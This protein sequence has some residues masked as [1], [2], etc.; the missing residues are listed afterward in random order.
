LVL[1]ITLVGLVLILIVDVFLPA[2][3]HSLSLNSSLAERLE[4]ALTTLIILTV[5]NV[6][7]HLNSVAADHTVATVS[8]LASDLRRELTPVQDRVR[9]LDSSTFYSS[10]AGACLRATHAVDL[11]YFRPLPPHGSPT[12]AKTAAYEDI[13]KLIA[14]RADLRIRLLVNGSSD[15]RAWVAN[16]GRSASGSPNVSI[17]FLGLSVPPDTLLSAQVCDGETTYLDHVA[18]RRPGVGRDLL[19]LSSEA[20]AIFAEYYDRLWEMRERF[21]DHGATVPGDAAGV[22]GDGRSGHELP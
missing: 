20:S 1:L 2:I 8:D 16:V 7:F 4:R 12:R 22:L 15:N 3:V 11:S 9:I 6:V 13:E 14:T 17:G 10:L 21:L 5:L 19:V 18:L